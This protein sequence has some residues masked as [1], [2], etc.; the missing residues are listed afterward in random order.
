M[1]AAALRVY[2]TIRKKGVQKSLLN[3]MQTRKE[4]YPFLG[5]EK[6]ERMIDRLLEIEKKEKR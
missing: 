4:L 6:Y 1:N 5:Y 2:Q 3:K